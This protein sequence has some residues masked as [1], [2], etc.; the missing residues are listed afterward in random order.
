MKLWITLTLA[1]F[2]LHLMYGQT[3]TVNFADPASPD[4]V[5]TWGTNA[6]TCIGGTLPDCTGGRWAMWAGDGNGDGKVEYVSPTSDIDLIVND[7][8]GNPLNTNFDFTLPFSGYKNADYNLDGEV[9]YVGLKSDQDVIVNSVF[10]N[11]LNTSLDF[12]LPV[13]SQIP[14]N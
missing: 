14:N 1:F 9:I 7:V 10:G 5:P 11:P 3:V 6:Q 12:T 8:F 4:F 2:G 13:F